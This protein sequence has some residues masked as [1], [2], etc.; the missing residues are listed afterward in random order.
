VIL[1]CGGAKKLRGQTSELPRHTGQIGNGD[2]HEK[3]GHWGCI[4]EREVAVEYLKAGMESLDN[5]DDR[6]LSSN[7]HP[8][9]PTILAVLKAVGM[10]LAV[11]PGDHAA[12]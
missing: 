7:G 2:N 8:A 6:G 3:K 12:A 11:E 4:T 9:L 10:K 1:L 5:P